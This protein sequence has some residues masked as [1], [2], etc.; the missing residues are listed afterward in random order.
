MGNQLGKTVGKTRSGI[1][2]VRHSISEIDPRYYQVKLTPPMR[3]DNR[4][5]PQK[6]SAQQAV[7]AQ[8]RGLGGKFR[9]PTTE[10]LRAIGRIQ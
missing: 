5:W 6:S 4:P 3:S 1:T 2:N 8:N 9:E 10:M 7:E